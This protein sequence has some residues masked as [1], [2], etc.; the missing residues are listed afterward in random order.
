MAQRTIV[1]LLDD[2]DG[3]RAD[4]TVTFSLDGV[5][6]Q[7][8]LSTKNANKLRKIFRPYI[9][10]A[11]KAGTRETGRSVRRTGARTTHSRE[12]A[13][14]VRAWARQQG[15]PVNDRGRIPAQIAQAYESNDPSRAKDRAPENLQ[16]KFQAASS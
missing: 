9:E 16:P 11:R 2:I 15:I 10:K 1:Q 13:A 14:D 4:E 3:K 5:T 12:R 8:D 7:I 6:Y